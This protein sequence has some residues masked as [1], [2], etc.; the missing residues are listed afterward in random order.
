MTRCRG[1]IAGVGLLLAGALGLTAGIWGEARAAIVPISVDPNGVLHSVNSYAVSR[2][3]RLVAFAA[4][5]RFGFPISHFMGED[6]FVLDR[7]TGELKWAS[8]APDGSEGVPGDVDADERRSI[9][10]AVAADGRSVVFQSNASNFFPGDALNT[11]DIFVHDLVTGETAL[12]SRATNGE[13]ANDRS[14]WPSISNDGRFVVF[15]STAT[16]LDPSASSGVF[17]H[18]RLLGTTERVS[19]ASDGTR[20]SGSSA[21]IS[22]DGRFVAFRGARAGDPDGPGVFVRDLQEGTTERVVES[23]EVL[24]VGS[25][26][27][28]KISDDGRIVGFLAIRIPDSVDEIFRHDRM[29]GGTVHVGTLERS[30]EEISVSSDGRYL[31]YVPPSS[32]PNNASVDRP[33]LLYDA[34]TDATTRIDV[35]N[36]G[37]LPSGHC[38]TPQLAADASVIAF[39][40]YS[41]H[42]LVPCETPRIPRGL[43]LYLADAALPPP[44][45]GGS[46]CG[47]FACD[48]GDGCTLDVCA[49]GTCASEPAPLEAETAMCVLEVDWIPAS[50]EGGLLPPAF[51]RRL[52]RITVRLEKI[53]GAPAARRKALGRQVERRLTEVARRMR[54]H[55]AAGRIE[56]E[57]AAALDASLVEA[58]ARVAALRAV[59]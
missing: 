55:A 52:A 11:M 4:A 40:H 25:P 30:V 45:G 24:A 20:M 56:A 26:S 9:R 43:V 35:A 51:E 46:A 6:I 41:P 33:C 36:T 12:V 28:P 3:G 1:R 19:V 22:G 23:A 50:C 44:C 31:G 15:E 42:G 27:K 54:R 29:T 34:V 16:N 13:P 10:P 14:L 18:D 47:A 32:N 37:T 57:C 21:S 58:L 5:A 2:D 8:V 53:P 38:R 48:D 59:L 49:A 39:A 7:A 17:V